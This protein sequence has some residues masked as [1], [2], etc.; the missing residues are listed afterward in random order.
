M[1]KTKQ[2][3]DKNGVKMS[4]KD[5]NTLSMV[6]EDYKTSWDYAQNN[7]HD[8]WE[9]AWK[10]YNNKRVDQAYT[11]VS[12]IFIPMTF[13][14]IES[15]VSAL[16]G[17][18]PRFEFEPVTPE[19]DTDVKVLNAMMDFYWDAD[20]WQSKVDK[21][22]RSMLMYGT[23][24]LYIWWDI[25][26]PR[27]AIVP[28]KDFIIDPTASAPEYARFMGRRY[29]TTKDELESYKYVDPET[30]KVK[31]LY[32]NLNKVTSGATGQGEEMDKDQKETFLG[33]T[34]GK[35]ASSKQVEVIE[36]W[37]KDRVIAVANRKVVI[38]DDENPYKEA[39]R[40]REG[41]DEFDTDGIIPFIVQRNYQDESLV[42][43]KGDI[44]PIMGLQESLN[45]LAN[46]RRDSISYQLNPMFTLDPQYAD[47]LE[48]VESL[49]GAVYP[50]QAGAL[51][52]IEM[53]SLSADSFNEET[54]I[55]QDIRETTAADQVFKGADTEGAKTATEV[56]A[57]LAQ[58]NQRLALKVSQIEQEG[59]HDLAEI[60]LSMTQ[61]F[62]TEPQAIKIVGANNNVDWVVYDPEQM[63]GMFEP[64]V[65]LSST[66]EAQ[67]SQDSMQAK[68][69]YSM[70]LGDP[71]VNQTE[72][73]RLT[74]QRG[75][76]LDQE[77]IDAL[78]QVDMQ[79]QPIDAQLTPDMITGLGGLDVGA[80]GF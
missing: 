20:Q 55:K 65:R 21:W 13:S 59:Y 46:Q 69:I 4:N 18:R 19:Q 17:S 77:E 68:E 24:V 3:P 22:L 1:P 14:T 79:E 62:V 54:L 16:A 51:Q 32:K 74:L 38:R 11:G 30:N 47:H 8:T 36:Y 31:K 56:S 34:L 57:Q 33:S 58:A 40:I 43:G 2:K 35:E 49:P 70:F 45:D 27:L 66:I 9:Q 10:L 61:L 80:L 60:C 76:G 39:K 28:L 12:D 41:T 52:K 53:G 64:K 50:F 75:Y 25:D 78:L 48:S 15:M 23:G 71:E 29:L 7:Y 6:L 26:R 44:E 73:K 72:L 5:R 42:Y 67:K 63:D 37:T